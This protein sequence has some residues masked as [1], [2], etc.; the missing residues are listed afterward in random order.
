MGDNSTAPDGESK[1]APVR[2]LARAGHVHHR[3][4]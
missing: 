2:E 3:R 4:C 1:A